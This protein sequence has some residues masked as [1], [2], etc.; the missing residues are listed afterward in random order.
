M[1]DTQMLLFAGIIYIAP[2]MD[3]R[4]SGIFGAILITIVSIKGLLT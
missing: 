4:I 1:T 2:S 3:T